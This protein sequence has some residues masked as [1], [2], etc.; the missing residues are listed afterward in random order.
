M[1]E[2]LGYDFFTEEDGAPLELDPVYGQAYGERYNKKVGILAYEI[3]QLI[4]TFDSEAAARAEPQASSKPAVYLA[5]CGYDRK[6]ARELLDAELRR[7]GHA[8]LP[9]QLLPTDQAEYI[10]AVDGMLA[11]CALAIHLVGER[12][13]VVLDGPTAKSIGVLQNEAA[14]ARCKSG[15]LKRLIWLPQGT[16]SGDPGQQA[17]IDALHQDAEVQFGA[18]LIT[19]DIELLRG[20]IH[21]TLKKIEQPE[22]SQPERDNLEVRDAAGDCGKLMYF[23]LDEKDRKASVPLR[24]FCRQSGF[25]VALPAFEGDASQ[26]RKNNQQLL[27]NCDV[28]LLFYGAGDEAWKTAMDSELK[29]MA[30]YRG[31]KPPPT[32]Y[33]YLAEPRTNDKDELI[34]LE[35]AGLIN[36]LGGF[37]EETVAKSIKPCKP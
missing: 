23:I 8:V 3:S 19:G 14:V 25:Q 9:D 18:D 26:I 28:V 33:T 11:R 29:K 2:V 17:F 13:G 1:R 37:V 22:Q 6:Q 35:E 12:G 34:D 31:S 30:G 20:A 32:F 24:K 5:E 7:L 10:A 27:E 4:K 36:G 16:R 21:N 15:A